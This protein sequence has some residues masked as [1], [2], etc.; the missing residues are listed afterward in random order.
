MCH[1]GGNK[2]LYLL[3]GVLCISIFSVGCGRPMDLATSE[4]E[5]IDD[6][7]TTEEETTIF[8]GVSGTEES[9]ASSTEAVTEEEL[10]VSD[11]VPGE[12]TLFNLLLTARE[13]V[14]HTMYIW[15]GGWNE[16]DTAAGEEA[17]SIGVS[18]RWQEFADQQNSYYNHDYTRYQIHDGLD[19]SGY[20]GW[21]IYNVFEHTDGEPG[22]VEKASGMAKSF[23][24]RGWGTYIPAGQATD[25]K[26]GDIMSMSGH[27]WISLG[28]CEDGSVLLFHA[29]PPG[30]ILCGTLLQDGSRSR[31]VELAEHY[32]STYYPDWYGRYPDCAR[33]AYYLTNSGQMRWNQETLGDEEQIQEMTGEEVMKLLFPEE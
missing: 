19:C 14:G 13:P 26:P 28:T 27:V 22:Y 15:G 2:H 5:T 21:V 12:Q 18:P 20:V 31:A 25:W 32:M 29:S 10:K 8:E 4:Y 9:A 17:R 24:E 1:S 11:P 30:V 3:A 16:E 6:I 33:E 23:A 7:L